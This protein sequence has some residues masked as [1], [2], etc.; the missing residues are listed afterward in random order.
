MSILFII[1]LV[2]LF[3]AAIPIPWASPINLFAL[4]MF[5]WGLSKV[6]T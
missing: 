5:F 3:L 1:A 2:C 6:V 4:G